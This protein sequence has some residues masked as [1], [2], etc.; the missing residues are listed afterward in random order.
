MGKIF[1]V[2]FCRIRMNKRNV[3]KEN[4]N[5]FSLKLGKMREK[6]REREKV[7]TFQFNEFSTNLMKIN[8]IF[9]VA[10][11]FQYD[12]YVYNLAHLSIDTH[13]TQQFCGCENSAARI[14]G[15][16]KTIFFVFVER[17][18]RER[19]IENDFSCNRMK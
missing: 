9:V 17:S 15:S 18:K 7:Y 5:F 3:S 19:K 14:N 2:I 16:R 8:Y 6:E 1:A 12:Q 4:G 11:A 13:N 10:T